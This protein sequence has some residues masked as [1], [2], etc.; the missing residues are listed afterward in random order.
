MEAMTTIDF[1]AD[2]G[3]DILAGWMDFGQAEC[4]PWVRPATRQRSVAGAEGDEKTE[5]GAVEHRP[6]SKSESR[7]VGTLKT[8]QR[9]K[10]LVEPESRLTPLAICNSN[11][12]GGNRNCPA[13]AFSAQSQPEPGGQEQPDNLTS[14]HVPQPSRNE[15][16][17]EVH[18]ATFPSQRSG[19]RYSRASSGRE[20]AAGELAP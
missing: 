13:T 16:K 8:A 12:D 4:P 18:T 5:F 2:G 14:A 11:C 19:S 6:G 3:I 7:R 9:G 17:L 20:D 10:T 1:A 15:G